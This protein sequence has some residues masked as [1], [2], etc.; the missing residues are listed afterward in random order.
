MPVAGDCGGSR[1]GGADAALRVALALPAAAQSG[2]AF[3]WAS[4][5]AA[6]PPHTKRPGCPGRPHGG[7]ALQLQTHGCPTPL[8]KGRS[9]GQREHGAGRAAAGGPAA[10]WSAELMLVPFLSFGVVVAGS[11]CPSSP[12][13]AAPTPSPSLPH[14]TRP[15]S[16]AAAGTPTRTPSPLFVPTLSVPRDYPVAGCQKWG[17]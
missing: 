5:Q 6:A 8:G 10:R 14:P 2:G 16:H 12:L 3:S 4:A 11:P 7:S 13:P 15:A 9:D 1:S 17:I